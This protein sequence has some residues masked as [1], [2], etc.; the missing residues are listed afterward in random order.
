MLCF[1]VGK[2]L[3]YK[4]EKKLLRI[5]KISP[6]FQNHETGMGGEGQCYLLSTPFN[7]VL[8]LFKFG[9]HMLRWLEEDSLKI[10]QTQYITSSLKSWT[11]WVWFLKMVHQWNWQLIWNYQVI[12]KTWSSLKNLFILIILTSK[13]DKVQIFTSVKNKLKNDEIWSGLLRDINNLHSN[14]I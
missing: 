10:I 11:I 5:W 3:N 2:F 9:L 14:K 12:W 4:F 13:N 6:N 1:W 8:F 7:I